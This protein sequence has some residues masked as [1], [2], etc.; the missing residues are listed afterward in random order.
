[1]STPAQDALRDAYEKLPQASRDEFARLIAA[2]V[3]EVQQH[4]RIQCIQEIQQ[5]ASNFRPIHPLYEGL[6]GAANVLRLRATR[7]DQQLPAR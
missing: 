7:P 6:H 1:M 5:A 2:A 3:E 4:E